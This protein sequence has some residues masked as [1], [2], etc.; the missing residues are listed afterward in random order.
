[1]KN[2]EILNLL[3]FSLIFASVLAVFYKIYN[4][5]GTLK[6]DGIKT[7][8]VVFDIELNSMDGDVKSMLQI[9]VI[10]FVTKDGTWITHKKEG[11]NYTTSP[12]KK[13]MEVYVYYNAKNPTEFIIETKR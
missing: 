7:T 4:R 11:I 2:E 12:F 13:G 9:P 10:R 3:F 5:A 1:M 6:K 8:G